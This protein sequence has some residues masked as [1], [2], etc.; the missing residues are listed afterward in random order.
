MI[1]TASRNT[2][3]PEEVIA[4]LLGIQDLAL[5]RHPARETENGP[6]AEFW[7]QHYWRAFV[8]VPGECQAS[9]SV[10]TSAKPWQ[11]RTDPNRGRKQVLKSLL[12]GSLKVEPPVPTWRKAIL[13][14]EGEPVVIDFPFDPVPA[15]LRHADLFETYEFNT[16]AGVTYGFEFKTW[17]LAS[18][19]SFANPKLPWLRNLTNAL[20]R[21]ADTVAMI[22]GD[23]SVGRFVARWKQQIV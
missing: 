11:P 22:T 12:R 2:H 21:V 5:G 8:L 19:F 20:V 14:L 16:E 1:V 17:N 13:A 15:T 18:S 6:Q 9:L 4:S 3:L 10:V 23:R 7:L